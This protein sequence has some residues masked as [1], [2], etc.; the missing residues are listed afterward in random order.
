MCCNSMPGP[1]KAA[2]SQAQLVQNGGAFADYSALAATRL[3]PKRAQYRYAFTMQQPS[4]SP[5]NL[6]F[7]LGGPPGKVFLTGIS[8]F[9]LPVAD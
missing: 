1:I 7:Q 2:T 3:T 5:V 8:L 9:R 4:D 6:L